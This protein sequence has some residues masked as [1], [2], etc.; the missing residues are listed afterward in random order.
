MNNI[1]FF[2]FANYCM[3]TVQN[4]FTMQEYTEFLVTSVITVTTNVPVLYDENMYRSCIASVAVSFSLAKASASFC[5]STW[6]AANNTRLLPKV[7]SIIIHHHPP[8]PPLPAAG[9]P[10]TQLPAGCAADL[11]LMLWWGRPAAGKRRICAVNY[12]DWRGRGNR[13]FT[14]LTSLSQ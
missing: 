7:T 13:F 2:Y 1:R 9:P 11:W 3:P 4:H 5:T 6:C 14:A 12:G 10:R 8:L